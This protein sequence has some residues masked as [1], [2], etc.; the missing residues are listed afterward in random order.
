MKININLFVLLFVLLCSLR[1]LVYG[2]TEL[3]LDDN[4][5][6]NFSA[7]VSID[8][9]VSANRIF[10]V[11][12]EFFSTN[13]QNFNR[14]NSEKNFQGSNVWL[15]TPKKNAEQ[16]D[17]LYRNDEPISLSEKD[18]KKIIARVVNK[19]TGGT[20]GCIR[21]LYI[22]FDII[23]R[24]KNGRYKYEFTNFIYTHYNQASMQQSQIYGMSDK[25]LCNSKNTLENL[26]K[27]DRCN[28][29]FE[30]FYTYLKSDTESLIS[31]MKK[32]IKENKEKNDDW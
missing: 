16:V 4:Q 26:L 20:M 13:I 27:C 10:N 31:E 8:S 30:K 7:V 32:Y 24:A 12:K 17:L 1:T 9:S 3:P 11:A 5:M 21:V 6:V 19:Y 15:G 25:G 14:S 29:E 28:R 23:L 2:Q 22:E 18:Q